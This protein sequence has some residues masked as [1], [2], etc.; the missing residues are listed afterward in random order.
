MPLHQ[1]C[2][3]YSTARVSISPAGR[4]HGQWAQQGSTLGGAGV[5]ARSDDPRSWYML[6]VCWFINPLLLWYLDM[7]N[8]YILYYIILCYI[9]LYYVILYYII[10]YY[11][12]IYHYLSISI[13]YIH[14]YI[15]IYTQWFCIY[16]N[17]NNTGT[18]PRRNSKHLLIYSQDHPG[19][20]A[21]PARLLRAAALV[22]RKLP[23]M[24]ICRLG[25]TPFLDFEAISYIYTYV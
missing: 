11:I 22:T 17:Y 14:I 6:R 5:L 12:Y 2:I 25:S 9:V 4:A 23:S 18:L 13:I 8:Y 7:Y 21:I 19:I 24:Q 15:Y 1:P 20:L 16:S 10:L 3:I